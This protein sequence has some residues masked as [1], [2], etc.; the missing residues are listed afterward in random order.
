[1]GNKNRFYLIILTFF[2]LISCTSTTYA[3]SEVST[4]RTDG[5]FTLIETQITSVKSDQIVPTIY[6]DRIVWQDN[7]NGNWDIYMY[8]L[9]SSTETSITANES[10]Q[11][12]P[13]IYGDRIVWQDDRNGNWDI[14][15]YDLST[16][17]ETQ[18]TNELTDQVSPDIHRDRIVWQD[19]RNENWDIY[20]YDLST[21]KETQITTNNL[22]QMKPRIYG[23]R[24]VWMDER[25][26][27][28]LYL[29]ELSTPRMLFNILWN[30]KDL[31]LFSTI[32]GSNESQTQRIMK[33]LTSREISIT[34]CES[35][36]YE[37]PSIYGNKIV[38]ADRRSAESD[39][40]YM[41]NPGIYI[42]DISTS[43]E[44]QV[45]PGFVTDE[46]CLL[47]SIF[48]KR[49]VWQD[50]RNGNSDIY[51]YDLST[52]IET[53]IT[54]NE[55]KQEMP[56]IYMNKIVWQDERNG[57]WDIYMC[58]LAPVNVKPLSPVSNAY[59]SG[60]NLINQWLK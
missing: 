44:T 52:S 10:N 6:G 48:E 9:S 3:A 47:P 35:Y 11:T 57:N 27:K 29:Y 37:F 32:S 59:N 24:I 36:E 17:K 40:S 34:T 1:M 25:N 28:E 4:Q 53:R 38:W 30:H 39:N 12:E 31:D 15:M 46:P 2:F 45:T 42:Y 21:H 22:S 33:Y 51:T 49:I 19:E 16:Q 18:I 23:D 26:G 56:F 43:T 13:A 50:G 41:N 55:S 54:T 14:Y 7:R 5:Q 60:L 58:T 8:N 20:M